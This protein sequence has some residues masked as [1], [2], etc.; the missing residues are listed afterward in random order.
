M[1]PVGITLGLHIKGRSKLDTEYP[2]KS[3]IGQGPNSS[4]IYRYEYNPFHS[5]RQ[6]ENQSIWANLWILLLR[7]LLFC[8]FMVPYFTV[9]LIKFTDPVAKTILEFGSLLVSILSFF[10]CGFELLRKIGWYR[11][12][13]MVN[14]PLS[15]DSKRSNRSGSDHNAKNVL[16]TNG[17]INTS[18]G[19][20]TN[21]NGHPAK[22][23][24]QGY[25]FEGQQTHQA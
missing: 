14:L 8:V 18:H 12:G 10:L 19:N 24:D 7:L 23:G 16:T 3:Q 22:F 20:Q 5:S 1:V 13:D 17:P 9:I 11:A 25:H 6:R 15:S 21:Q 4:N 2:P